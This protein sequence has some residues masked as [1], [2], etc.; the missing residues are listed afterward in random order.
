MK[1]RVYI[2]SM[3]TFTH[4]KKW[5]DFLTNT[6][7][8]DTSSGDMNEKVDHWLDSFEKSHTSY[9][10]MPFESLNSSF[11]EDILYSTILSPPGF[12]NREN[13]TRYYLN[14]TMQLLYFNVLVRQLILNIDC[15]T[16][17]IGV[18]KKT[19]IF[20]IITKISWMWRSYRNVSVRYI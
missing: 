17:V 3:C 16:M 5:Y 1:I 12:I 15:Y 18:D 7:K 14:A 13:E 2:C 11:P 20:F 9:I 6:W 10:I 4:E 19:N 8:D